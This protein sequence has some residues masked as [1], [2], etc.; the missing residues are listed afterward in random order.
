MSLD[1]ELSSLLKENLWAFSLGFKISKELDVHSDKIYSTTSKFSELLGKKGSVEYPDK[2]R[3]SISNREDPVSEQYTLIFEEDGEIYLSF[4]KKISEEERD[5]CYKEV[6]PKLIK[7]MGI[8]LPMIR[9]VDKVFR[10]YIRN[11]ENHYK[12]FFDHFFKPSHSEILKSRLL[13]RCDPSLLIGLD[14]NGDRICKINW[15]GEET[16]P[17][18]II[19]G[20]FDEKNDIRVRCGIAQ[21][22]KI[23]ESGSLESLLES[24]KEFARK[25]MIEELIPKVLKPFVEAAKERK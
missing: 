12:I 14:K 19:K 17:G 2:R 13:L 1:T 11:Q 6:F 21:V 3:I 23:L 9:W 10:L 18:E 22:D 20:V 5:R 25:F 4:G 16:T 15:S 24:H 7:E 8:S